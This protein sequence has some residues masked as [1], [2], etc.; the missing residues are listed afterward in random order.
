MPSNSVSRI[1]TATLLPPRGPWA[2]PAGFVLLYHLGNL[3]GS[4]SGKTEQFLS[5]EAVLGDSYN[6]RL[7][8][9][10]ETLPV[11]GDNLTLWT[12]ECCSKFILFFV[13]LWL[14]PS[15]LIMSIFKIMLDPRRN[16][17]EIT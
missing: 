16:T 17:T 15:W 13:T 2:T 3:Q 1:S 10:A 5:L 9:K 14:V 4:G 7:I 6:S 8:P 11:Y 12:A